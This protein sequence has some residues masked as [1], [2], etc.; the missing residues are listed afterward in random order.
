[1]DVWISESDFCINE[2]RLF[3][4]HLM[5]FKIQYGIKCWLL[6]PSTVVAGKYSDDILSKVQTYTDTYTE[7]A[8]G[9]SI[10]LSD[11]TFFVGRFMNIYQTLPP[12]RKRKKTFFPHHVN[13]KRF[14]SLCQDGTFSKRNQSS[15][16]IT[17]LRSF[18]GRRWED[19][20]RIRSPSGHFGV[21]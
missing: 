21:K 8:K 10:S 16:L 15:I 18:V 9:H 20:T 4:Q 7:Q 5:G 6:Q 2:F 1:M 11:I 12:N 13:H 17:F 14:H 19:G 3:L